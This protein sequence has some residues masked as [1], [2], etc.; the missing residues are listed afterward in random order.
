MEVF[1]GLAIGIATSLAASGIWFL[2]RLK[3]N[4]A[5][6]ARSPHG[7][8]FNLNRSR[9]V[10]LVFKTRDPD[11]AQTRP[12]RQVGMEDMLSVNYVSRSLSLCG[13][14]DN[15]LEFR[16]QERFAPLRNDGDRADDQADE[17]LVLI[18]SHDVTK[19]ALD[20][21][22][23]NKFVDC[24]F[25]DETGTAQIPR[26][27]IKLENF[28]TQFSP[29]FEQEVAMLQEN[30]ELREGMVEDYALIVKGP[31]PWSRKH[32]KLIM[33]AGVR[34]I[35]T[36]GAARYLRDHPEQI[37]EEFG[38]NNFA[39]IVKVTYCNWR[40]EDVRPTKFKA[41]LGDTLP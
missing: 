33:I 15:R 17:N 12:F 11:P 6:L 8:V 13:W 4:E 29:S 1:F 26:I 25:V 5:R 2:G 7:L 41:K 34:G 20:V 10:V 40:I 39:L 3:V 19:A 30:V 22:R 24:K 37:Y 36:W 38:T 23:S 18:C 16:A 32:G 21:Y 27:G 28:D 14:D 9:D 31:N 35:G